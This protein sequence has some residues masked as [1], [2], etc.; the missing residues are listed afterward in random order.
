MKKYASTLAKEHE[1]GTN[2]NDFFAYIVES[3]LNGQRSQVRSLFNSMKTDCKHNFLINYLDI[4]IG[5]Q[6][7]CLNICIAEMK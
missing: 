6:K 1:L 3:L 5:I 2:E 4:S 7:S